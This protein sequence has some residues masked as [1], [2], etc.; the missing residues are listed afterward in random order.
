MPSFYT[1]LY[2]N[3]TLHGAIP[4][5]TNSNCASS[6]LPELHVLPSITPHEKV[7]PDGFAHHK[8]FHSITT[9]VT[10]RGRSLTLS[11]QKGGSKNLSSGHCFCWQLSASCTRVCCERRKQVNASSRILFPIQLSSAHFSLGAL[12]VLSVRLFLI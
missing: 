9:A 3:M 8:P 6:F 10:S 2:M 7:D 12:P 11:S 5:G 1:Y 4:V